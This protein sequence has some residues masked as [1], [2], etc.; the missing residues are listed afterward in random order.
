MCSVNLAYKTAEGNGESWSSLAFVVGSQ[1]TCRWKNQLSKYS[2]FFSK[3]LD[4]SF[5]LAAQ[6]AV[7]EPTGLAT[8]GSLL[9]M[10]NLRLHYC[11]KL[12]ILTRL[13]G[14]SCSTKC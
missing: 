2:E 6:T 9:E 7:H 4:V 5:H 1:P 11:T 8:L 14:E 3:A 13:P 10:Q 12:R